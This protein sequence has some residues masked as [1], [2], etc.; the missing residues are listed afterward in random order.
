MCAGR[1]GGGS[2]GWAGLSGERQESESAEWRSQGNELAGWRS[3]A[4]ELA[5]SAAG[6]R[7][8][9]SGCRTMPA[10]AVHI[11]IGELW[12]SHQKGP[13]PSGCMRGLC[14]VGVAYDCQC[15]LC[16]SRRLLQRTSP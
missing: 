12:F 16:F 13:Q 5:E 9:K 7:T 3:Q 6:C 10:Q 15:S 4:S 14:M 8:V 1:W 11:S 2:G